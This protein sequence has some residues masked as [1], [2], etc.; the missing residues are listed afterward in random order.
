MRTI[1]TLYF[2]GSKLRLV[3]DGEAYG[4]RVESN[5]TIGPTYFFSIVSKIISSL[6]LKKN[7]VL[8]KKNGVIKKQNFIITG[9]VIRYKTPSLPSRKV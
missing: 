9:T 8:Y 6:K 3:T 1:E 7:H 5:G 4:L 2:F